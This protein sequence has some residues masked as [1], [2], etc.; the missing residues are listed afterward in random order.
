[1]CKIVAE[2]VIGR[3][4]RNENIVSNILRNQG[5]VCIVAFMEGKENV[6]VLLL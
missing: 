2:G 1:M 5:G 6:S 4:T 3:K